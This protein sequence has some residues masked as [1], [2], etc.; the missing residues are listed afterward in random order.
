MVENKVPD[1]KKSA[2]R[3]ENRTHD[4]LS[5]GIASSSGAE[6]P[7]ELAVSFAEQLKTSPNWE[8][9][10]T[11]AVA[12]A[13]PDHVAMYLGDVKLGINVTLILATFKLSWFMSM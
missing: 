12:W 4:S 6:H 10:A 11:F 7:E 9:V 1:K 5:R 3:W 8:E 13:F 2:G